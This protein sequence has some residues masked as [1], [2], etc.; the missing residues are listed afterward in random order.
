MFAAAI[1]AWGKGGWLE[2]KTK[3]DSI[4]ELICRKVGA[5]E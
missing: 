2:T 3:T 1:T 4:A 5:V